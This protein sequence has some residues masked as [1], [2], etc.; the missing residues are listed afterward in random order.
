M[1][2]YALLIALTAL[3]LCASAADDDVRA[4]YLFSCRGCHLA[5]GSGVPPEV[6]SL[7]NSLGKLAASPRGRE[8]LMRVPGVLQSR[9]NDEQLADV[10][11]YILTE[12]NAETLPDNFTPVSAVE[13]TAARK[14]ILADPAKLRASLDDE[15]ALE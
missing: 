1:R 12:F 9:L 8:Y 2:A 11:N 15:L 3:P 14:Q 13:V 5:D 7:R 10:I 6:P 4:N